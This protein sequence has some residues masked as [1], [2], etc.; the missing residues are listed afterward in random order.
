MLRPWFTTSLDQTGSGAEFPMTSMVGSSTW[1]WDRRNYRCA[2]W[3]VRFTDENR[4]FVSEASVSPGALREL[5]GHQFVVVR[6]AAG[7]HTATIVGVHNEVQGTIRSFPEAFLASSVLVCQL[8]P[9]FQRL[10][11]AAHE[12][13]KFKGG[14][15]WQLRHCSSYGIV[16]EKGVVDVGKRFSRYPTLRALLAGGALGELRKLERADYALSSV[17]LLPTIPDRDKILYRC[18]TTIRIWLKSANRRR[19]MRL[20]LRALQTVRSGRPVYDQAAAVRTLRLRR[21]NSRYCWLRWRPYLEEDALSHVV[22]YA[23]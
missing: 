10:K 20:S 23:C 18:E 2:I 16:T 8:N 11:R 14:D 3:P 4:C 22:G 15:Y 19:R 9:A 1:R 13:R 5:S 6:N 7:G 21:L 12:D 17:Q